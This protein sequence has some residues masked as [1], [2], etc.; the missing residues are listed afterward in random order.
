M[1]IYD[2]RNKSAYDFGPPNPS[3]SKD[4]YILSWWSDEHGKLIR[5]LIDD[6]QW[7]WPWHVTEAIKKITPSPI[8]DDWR[9]SDSI[10]KRYAW[11]NVIMYFALSWAHVHGLT[12]KVR[13][14]LRKICPLCQQ[15]FIESSLP[16][17]L[18][19]RLGING[20][21]YCSPCLQGI[22]FHG[23]GNSNSSKEDVRE[24]LIK[25]S[26]V[27]KQIP[28]QG[29]GEGMED[30]RYLD[31]QER[32]IILK[33]LKE[34]PSVNRV[35]QLFGSW[36]E[37][38]IDSG[39]LEDGTRK[40]SRGTQCLAKDGHICYSLAEKTIDDY[41]YNHNILHSKEPLY[42]GSNMRAD[43]LVKSTFI[44]YFGLRG[45]PEYDSKTEIKKKRCCEHGL[46]LLELYPEDLVSIGK[47][48]EKIFKLIANNGL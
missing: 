12:V 28:H 26:D 27:L 21:D 32:L 7:V 14:P 23:T 13:S 41:M 46:F 6:W 18:V 9:A 2:Q 8:L 22:V 4:P 39:I 30:L 29:F 35:R 42:P 3:Y 45:N 47:L 24:Y 5:E 48:E 44:E 25:L 11:Y 16:V 38:L 1:T 37:A 33:I 20:L 40:T 10:C 17:P 15:E 19:D 34:K 31:I 36:L 43:F